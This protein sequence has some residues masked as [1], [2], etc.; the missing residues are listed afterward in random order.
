MG[1]LRLSATTLLRDVVSRRL[2][3]LP[4]IAFHN[5]RRIAVL[6]IP[7]R[8]EQFLH[9]ARTAVV[10]KQRQAQL[11]LGCALVALQQVSQV[12]E[13]EPE[14]RVPVVQLLHRKPGLVQPSGA[15][16]HWVYPMA[17]TLLFALA[18]KFDSVFTKRKA[19]AG[20]TPSARAMS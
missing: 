9:L 3:A 13:P 4:P 19:R 2:L 15:R 17:P 5:V 18:V 20:S 6:R 10:G 16:Q 8:V 11:R 1:A 7:P 12:A 14:V